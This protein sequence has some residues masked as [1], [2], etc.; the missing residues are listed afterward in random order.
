MD[1]KRKYLKYKSKYLSLSQSS[2]SLTGGQI[3]GNIKKYELES[4]KK[5]SAGLI[6]GD[7]IFF[8]LNFFVT[9]YSL[10]YSYRDGP[11]YRKHV[12]MCSVHRSNQEN[13]NFFSC[14]ASNSD[15]GSW[16]LSMMNDPGVYYKGVNYITS[17]LI[18][19][20]LQKY[21]NSSIKTYKPMIHNITW[22]NDKQT[23]P[24]HD[25]FHT[26]RILNENDGR[27]RKTIAGGKW[28]FSRTRH[29]SFF[30]K[31]EEIFKK[32]YGKTVDDMYKRF[33]EYIAEIRSDIGNQLK[34]NYFEK[35]K[36]MLDTDYNPMTIK[37]KTYA[38][39]FIKAG[40]PDIGNLFNRINVF[41]NETGTICGNAIS[42]RIGATSVPDRDFLRNMM[43]YIK[44]KYTLKIDQPI[45]AE[46]T[47]KFIANGFKDPSDLIGQATLPMGLGGLNS[48]S[49]VPPD[50]LQVLSGHPDILDKFIIYKDA[51]DRDSDNQAKYFD[52]MIIVAYL[53]YI[54]PKYNL[55]DIKDMPEEKSTFDDPMLNTAHIDD[56]SNNTGADVIFGNMNFGDNVLMPNIT[57]GSMDFGASNA[58]K[59]DV[60]FDDMNIGNMDTSDISNPFTLGGNRDRNKNR[61]GGLNDTVPMRPDLKRSFTFA[62][63]NQVGDVTMDDI[64]NHINAYITKS[65]DIEDALEKLTMFFRSFATDIKKLQ[66]KLHMET[67]RYVYISLK[68]EMYS[69]LKI[70]FTQTTLVSSKKIT[71][72]GIVFDTIL[73]ASPVT[74]KSG[75]SIL[76]FY[77]YALRRYDIKNRPQNWQTMPHYFEINNEH[78]TMNG[79]NNYYY[80]GGLYLCKPFEYI[81]NTKLKFST[82]DLSVG[83]GYNFAETAIN[84]NHTYIY[85]GDVYGDLNVDMSKP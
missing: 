7:M 72:D 85:L 80:E 27:N 10:Y 29:I 53:K 74:E 1:Y 20:L 57:F 71:V 42:L 2:Y 39:K 67:M 63:P 77:H 81:R 83:Y 21:I 16:R 24:P 41:S 6:V 45:I 26:V 82:D 52:E 68:R 8:I 79:I 11:D 3:G 64:N 59:Q 37:N 49:H 12:D 28:F 48:I 65:P 78:P 9:D 22:R 25:G 15:A 58:P 31:Y 40:F 17:N 69:V 38:D 18:H 43:V 75:N 34:M 46:L 70:D 73:Y 61:G 56:T 19:P 35:Y 47:R 51:V 50:M 66:N 62:P 44:N 76:T 23:Y 5:A 84:L 30:D 54:I 32:D 4:L 36:Q 13:V 33:P 14:Y 60:T 55:P